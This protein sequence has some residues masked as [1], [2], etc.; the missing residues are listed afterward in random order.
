MIKVWKGVVYL[1]NILHPFS[2]LSHGERMCSDYCKN[3]VQYDPICH[4]QNGKLSQRQYAVPGSLSAKTMTM[5]SFLAVGFLVL[6][7]A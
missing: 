2:F 5:R 1:R 6:S 4:M 7:S 3:L